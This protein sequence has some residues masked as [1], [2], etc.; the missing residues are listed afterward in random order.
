M[1][2]TNTMAQ[3]LLL[4]ATMLNRLLPPILIS[5]LLI[6]GALYACTRIDVEA[7]M[8]MKASQ[9]SMTHHVVTKGPCDDSRH[10]ICK[11]VRQRMVSLEASR[12]ESSLRYS[13]IQQD[14]LSN[15]T[16]PLPVSFFVALVIPDRVAIGFSHISPPIVLRI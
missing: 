13:A 7:F 1:R 14:V 12:S 11:S 15:K 9:S 5:L 3:L 6:Y 4:D 10:D 8:E 16:F 2:K